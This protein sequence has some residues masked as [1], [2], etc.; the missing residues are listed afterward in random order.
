MSNFL[1]IPNNS[2][3]V[4]ATFTPATSASSFGTHYSHFG[5]GGFVE[6]PSISLRNSIPISEEMNS[7][8]LSSGRRKLGMLVYVAENQKFYQL[9]PRHTSTSGG[10]VGSYVTFSQWATASNAQKMVWLDPSQQREN[11]QSGSSIYTLVTGSGNVNEVWTDWTDISISDLR[12]T[13]LPLSGGTITGNLTVQGTFTTLGT[14]TFLS[15]TNLAIGDPIIHLAKDNPGNFFDMGF[16]T[17][18]KNPNENHSGLVRNY[19]NNEWFLFSGLSSV[20][21][22]SVDLNLTSPPVV[23]DTLNANLKGNLMQGTKIFGDL[24]AARIVPD[25]TLTVVGSIST[26]HIFQR[27]KLNFVNENNT[28]TFKLSD[29]SCMVLFSPITP[30]TAYVPNDSNENFAIG[31]S[32]NFATLSAVVFVEGR[33]GVTIRAAEGRNYLRVTN[34]AAT[35]LKINSNDW[36]LFGDIW[37]ETLN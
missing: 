21:L 8:G 25:Q 33:S 20:P 15:S 7:D 35:I 27:T 37:S 4:Y 36:L 10:M 2:S 13:Y 6:L 3:R 26:N 28:Y 18:Y 16:V 31:S 32:V 24:S 29:Q 9:R 12:N 1:S 17:H 19:Q 14:A 5:V 23:I 34:S 22:T 11:F 30:I